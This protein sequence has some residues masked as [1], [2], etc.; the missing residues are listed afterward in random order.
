MN[1]HVEYFVTGKKMKTEIKDMD[2]NLKENVKY[3]TKEK[4]KVL[5]K[6]VYKYSKLLKELENE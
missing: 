3:H 4:L 1:Q 2:K 5:R 6:L